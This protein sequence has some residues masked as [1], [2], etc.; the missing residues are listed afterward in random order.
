MNAANP[1]RPARDLEIRTAGL[2]WAKNLPRSVPVNQNETSDDPG[3]TPPP[4][5]QDVI[6]YG[7]AAKQAVSAGQLL[8][9]IEVARDGLARFG[10]D[11]LLQQQLALALAQTGALDAALEV[12]GEIQKAP[13]AE[14]D[15]ETLCLLGRVH[16]E[17]WRR[18]GDPAAGL[19]QL[20]QSCK[21][22]GD[23]YTLTEAY[24]PGINLAFTLAALGELDRARETARKVEKSCRTGMSHT[25]VK[26]DG[27]LVATLAEAL[28]HQGATGEAGKY[29][30]QAAG[31]FSG[32]WRDLASMRRQAHEIVGFYA[33]QKNDARRHWYDLATVRQRVRALVGGGEEGTAWI[34]R[35]FEFPSVVMFSGHMIDQAG[36]AKAR[37]SPERETTVRDAM[38]AHLKKIRPG[39][40][41]A[42][43]ACGADII[44]CELL[45]EMGA[46]VHLVLPCPIDTFKRQS[47]SF[48]GPEWERRFHNV[49]G[50]AATCLVASP[51]DFD[52]SETDPAAITR[53]V[54]ASRILTGLAVLQAQ[55]LDIGLEAIALWDGAPA[56][57]PGG[58]GSVVAAWARRGFKPHIITIE[59][60]A[61]TP[62]I[63]AGPVESPPQP[64]VNGISHDI[65]AMLFAEVVNYKKISDRQMPAFIGEFR[66]ALAKAVGALPT[67]PIAAESWGRSISLVFDQLPDAAN[68]AL[69][70]RDL[71]AST[72]WQERGLPADLGIRIVLHA[73]PVFVFHDPVL[74]R[75]SCVGAH[76]N[77][78]ARLGPITAA[79]QI[80]VS[81]EFAALCSADDLAAVGFEFLG[82]LRTARIFEDAPLYRLDRRTKSE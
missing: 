74:K 62:A 70:L 77:H 2:P 20:R 76:V 38:R 15:E 12:L 45:L 65:R 66:G 16:K 48:A 21:Y 14:R 68:C 19:A 1:V 55:A 35:C 4:F 61:P 52:V 80:Y 9:A 10:S 73:G 46:T 25:M 75:E 6:E 22:Y 26:P 3:R 23:A 29:Y 37:F 51:S 28:T 79:G 63:A 53:H 42:S 58:T 71:V 11:R 39:F 56:L 43:A 27:W 8:T 7:Q 49:L 47:V 59:P 72:A 5:S 81:Q 57:A 31:I 67:P 69:A 41:Y 17:L 60:G 18:A 44:F 33:Q 78:A 54:F 24:Y 40:G 36:R 34:D 50:Q 82:R 13:G 30:L 64:P 32:H